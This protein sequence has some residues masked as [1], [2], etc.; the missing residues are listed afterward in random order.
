MVLTRYPR[1][2]TPM[3]SKPGMRLSSFTTR[4]KCNV[5]RL[6]ASSSLSIP[7]IVDTTTVPYGI[8]RILEGVRSLRSLLYYLFVVFPFQSNDSS[9]P[10]YAK[11]VAFVKRIRLFVKIYVFQMERM[12]RLSSQ[13]GV[14][15]AFFANGGFHAVIFSSITSSL[16]H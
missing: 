8:G 9:E 10:R 14:A 3:P 15:V 2:L 11:L 16:I 13:L 7:S 5:S 12:K 1:S 4:R 6:K